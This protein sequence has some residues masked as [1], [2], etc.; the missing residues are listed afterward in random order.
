VICYLGPRMQPAVVRAPPGAVDAPGHADAPPAHHR[1]H[2]PPP[3]PAPGGAGGPPPGG[4]GAASE[5]R[6]VRAARRREARAPFLLVA[7]RHG[8]A[9]LLGPPASGPDE[10]YSMPDIDAALLSR[11]MPLGAFYRSGRPEGSAQTGARRHAGPPVLHAASAS[12]ERCL[13]ARACF[14]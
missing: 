5:A 7:Y 14:S 6:A 13:C 1:R 8:A 12:T 2:G 10:E 9:V 4:D 11:V 3:P